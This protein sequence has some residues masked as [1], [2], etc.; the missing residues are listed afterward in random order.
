MHLVNVAPHRPDVIVEVRNDRVGGVGDQLPLAAIDPPQ[1]VIE[2][3]EAV[4]G[5]VADRI[6]QE[7]GIAARHAERARLAGFRQQRK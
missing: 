7:L 1:H 6:V 5:A 3:R 4:S 2:K